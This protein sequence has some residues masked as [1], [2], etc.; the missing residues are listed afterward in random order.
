[1]VDADPPLF[2]I[3]F[4]SPCLLLSTQ[5]QCNAIRNQRWSNFARIANKIWTPFQ[6][7][8]GTAVSLSA[9]LI[10]FHGISVG[11][12]ALEAPPAVAAVVFVILL[13]LIAY[14][15]G[16]HVTVITLEKANAEVFK[17]THPRAYS[18]HKL[19]NAHVECFVVGEWRVHW[20]GL[21]WI[22]FS[23]FL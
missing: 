13:I 23:F 5:I 21:G 7:I 4:L 14:A 22:D 1:M 15:E 6:Y 10:M 2:F 19:T 9:I 18:V 20:V 16:Y 8:I 3:S 12:I 17:E 11:D